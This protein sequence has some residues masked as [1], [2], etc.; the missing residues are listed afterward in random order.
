ME[1]KKDL[2]KENKDDDS[3]DSNAP[4]KVSETIK[5]TV[6]SIDALSWIHQHKQINPNDEITRIIIFNLV[7]CTYIIA[8]LIEVSKT[9]YSGV[10]NSVLTIANLSLILSLFNNKIYVLV[11]Q[12]KVNNYIYNLLRDIQYDRIKIVENLSSLTEFVFL[13]H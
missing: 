9:A 5:E 4:N 13:T 2:E 1:D 12:I 10:V 3:D 7:I 6:K 11:S 8:P